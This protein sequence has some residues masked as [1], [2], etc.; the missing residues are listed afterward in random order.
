MITET[1]QHS[2]G[3]ATETEDIVSHTVTS[4]GTTVFISNTTVQWS[5]S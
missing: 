2:T 4:T 1:G 5:Q 3:F